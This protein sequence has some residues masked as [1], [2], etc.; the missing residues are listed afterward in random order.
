[1]KCNWPMVIR[2]TG[3]AAPQKILTNDEIAQRVETSNEWIVQRTGIRERRIAAPDESTLDIALAAS[4]QALE[5]AGLSPQDLDMIQF[6]TVTPNHT[7][8][9]TSCELQAALG[10]GQIPAFDLQAACSGFVYGL[11]NAAQ[12]LQTGLAKTILV[13]G[14]ETLSRITDTEDRGTCILFGDGAG[15]AVIQRSDNPE[16]GILSAE[17]GADG[18]RAKLIWVPAGGSIEPTSQRTINERLHYMKMEGREVYKF[19]VA[20]IQELVT[21]SL[22]EAGVGI[23]DLRLFIPHQSNI[24]IIE[25]AMEKLN[26]SRDQVIINIERYGNTSSASVP[27]ALHEAWAAGRIDRGDLVLMIGIG[28]G[29]TW[30]SA[31]LRL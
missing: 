8:P 18:S 4:R 23:A 11:V 7:L 6:A 24:R 10:C 19:A 27:L 22:E 16:Q 2:G 9:S 13:V 5:R 20:K 21:R 3:S 29:L 26:L 1:M 31:L 30:G 17:L 12:H 25:S 15:A 14:A 28:A